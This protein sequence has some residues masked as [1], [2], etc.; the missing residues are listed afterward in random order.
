MGGD[1]DRVV[2]FGCGSSYHAALLGRLYLEDVAG[3][4][5][6][7]EYATDVAERGLF[8]TPG[9]AWVA[10]TQ[11]GETRDT[12]AA[13]EKVRRPTNEYFP[14]VSVLTNVETSQA[15]AADGVEVVPLGCGPE[16]GVA[17]TKTFTIQC[18]R[19]LEMAAGEPVGFYGLATAIE[20]VLAREFATDAMA[21]A[22]RP[23]RNI[24]YLARG[25]LLPIAMEG[26]LKMKEVA[27]RHAE[28]IHSSEMKHGPI[29]LV[30]D[31]TLSVFLV[32]HRDAEYSGLVYTHMEEILARGGK[33]AA[34]YDEH[35]RDRVLSLGVR[36]GLCLPAVEPLLYPLLVN[37]V[38]QVLA[39]KVAVA[40]GLDVDRPRS[41]AKC[42]TVE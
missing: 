8:S 12:L 36:N 7:A 40:D 27:Y 25:L 14:N 23:Y 32:S 29:A 35:S 5:A 15:A 30:D 42:V 11:S 18:A 33:V 20:S 26:A 13:L 17:A 2:L 4:P 34:V 31:S 1:V 10:L 19:L 21:D 37:V 28:A 9:T 39:Y 16:L 24:L 6:Q 41:L 3:V 38:L 22:V